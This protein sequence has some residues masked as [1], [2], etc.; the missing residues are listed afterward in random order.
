M[1]VSSQQRLYFAT[2]TK[3]NNDDDDERKTSDEKKPRVGLG[4]FDFSKVE[5]WTREHIESLEQQEWIH[6]SNM[7]NMMQ[8][9]SSSA[10]CNEECEHFL[11]AEQGTMNSPSQITKRNLWDKD[12]VQVLAKAYDDKPFNSL[13]TVI[14]SRHGHIIFSDPDYGYQ[15]GFRPEPQLKPSV[16][17]LDAKT[18]E[19][20]KLGTD[21]FFEMPHGLCLSRDEKTLFV[22]DTSMSHGENEKFNCRRSVYAIDFDCEKGRVTPGSE[23]RK[24]FAVDEGMPDGTFMTETNHL[25]VG[26][27]DG[28]YCADGNTGCLVGKIKLAKPA[29][30][31]CG[32]GDHDEN[33]FIT[34]DDGVVVLMKWMDFVVDAN[35]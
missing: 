15:Q 33:A 8:L 35:Y 28:I 9:D 29:V 25:L 32:F 11:I 21:A 16:Y 12:S 19:V 10:G 30:N 5:A 26:A 23:P 14:Q 27:G 17:V 2:T 4:F 13:N 18:D 22:T 24:C 1:W 3:L 20:S 7:V 34:V 6:D 31:L